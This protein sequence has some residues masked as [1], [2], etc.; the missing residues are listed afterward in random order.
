MIYKSYIVENNFEKIKENIVLF[1]GENVGLK[2]DLKKIIKLKKNKYEIIIFDND[3]L[4][5]NESLIIKEIINISLFDKDKIII[6]DQATDKILPIIEEILPKI[7]NNKIYLFADILEKKSKLRNFFEK[8]NNCGVVPCYH[9]NE[10]SIKKIINLELEGFE[11][12]TPINVKIIY[13]NVGLD[14]LRLKNEI[15]KIKTYFDDKKIKTLQLE[16]LLNNKATDDFNALKDEALNGNNAKTNKLLSETM[17]DSDKIFLY[18]NLINIRLRKLY[19]LSN[20]SGDSF[21]SKIN[22]FKPPVFWKE[23]PNYLI[24][25]RKWKLDKIKKLQDKTYDIE[26]KLKSNSNIDKNILI[27]YLIVD[28]CCL[29]NF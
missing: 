22:N 23:K 17:L 12:L 21:E 13:D 24:Q 5:K 3:E 6:V 18:L 26:I 9:D 15:V 27:K 19:D 1:Y 4:I 28:I 25:L 20:S 2:F 14:R 16:N 7:E 29:A 8:G 11:G 10:I